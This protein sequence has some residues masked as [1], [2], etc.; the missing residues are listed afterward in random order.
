MNFW[1]SNERQAAIAVM[2]KSAVVRKGD[3]I[4][5]LMIPSLISVVMTVRTK[6]ADIIE[7][8]RASDCTKRAVCITSIVLQAVLKWGDLFQAAL[9]YSELRVTWQWE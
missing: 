6:L 8:L 2:S 3:M 7:H 4:S 1:G 9:S 5:W